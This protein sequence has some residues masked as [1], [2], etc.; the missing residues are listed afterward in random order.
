[1]TSKVNAYDPETGELDD[2]SFAPR[3]GSFGRSRYTPEQQAE[4]KR[5]REERVELRRKEVA[6]IRA[7]DPACETEDDPPVAWRKPARLGGEPRGVLLDLPRLSGRGLR[8]SR[9]VLVARS[10]DGAG[11]NG[12]EAREYVSAYI[13]FRDGQGH[14]RRSVGV[15]IRPDELRPFIAALTKYADELDALKEAP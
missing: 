11:P 5:V 4:A 7:I 2:P 9:L 8:G 14:E 3:P 13:R 6:A 12:G 10:Y 15:A 1:M